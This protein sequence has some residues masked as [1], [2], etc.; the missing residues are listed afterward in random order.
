MNVDRIHN[1]ALLEEREIQVLRVSVEAVKHAEGGLF[2]DLGLLSELL[3]FDWIEYGPDIMMY[4]PKP[5]QREGVSAGGLAGRPRKAMNISLTFHGNRRA[6]KVAG[7]GGIPERKIF[8]STRVQGNISLM[9]NIPSRIR[10]QSVVA[11]LYLRNR[12]DSG[13][14][15]QAPPAAG[16]RKSKTA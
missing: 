16:S 13:S 1:G 4:I 9:K 10:V 15:S 14:R 2:L 6:A 8:A 7:A 11:G 3:F 12:Q 5:N